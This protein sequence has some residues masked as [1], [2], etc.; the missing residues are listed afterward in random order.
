MVFVTPYSTGT[1]DGNSPISGLSSISSTETMKVSCQVLPAS[2]LTV[3]V[4]VVTPCCSGISTN[5][6]S[7]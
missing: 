2:S 4:T 5:L 7:S 1:I 3:T 6:M